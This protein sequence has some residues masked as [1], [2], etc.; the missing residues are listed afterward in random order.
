MLPLLE[1]ILLVKKP[2]AGLPGSLLDEYGGLAR[3]AGF[4][5]EPI[6]KG[7]LLS[8][9]T[10][11]LAICVEFGS[12]WDFFNTLT[13]LRQKGADI[14]IVVTSSNSR[15]MPMETTYTVLKKK[16]HETVR[17]VLLDIEG[18]KRPM[19]LNF[20][21]Q[22]LGYPPFSGGD[23]RGATPTPSQDAQQARSQPEKKPASPGSAGESPSGD[24]R[25]ARIRGGAQRESRGA[26]APARRVRRNEAGQE[27]RK[28]KNY[29]LQPVDAP[30]RRKKI[31]G[32]PRRKR[33]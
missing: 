13:L 17:W 18:K 2:T 3:E 1:K 31:Y 28:T 30:A 26:Q 5:V 29:G 24:L 27:L 7:L 11:K 9:K 14:K 6:E 21:A 4:L 8:G 20:S 23:F 33:K 32:K 22:D 12:R 10:V 15:S 25:A 16:L 19:F